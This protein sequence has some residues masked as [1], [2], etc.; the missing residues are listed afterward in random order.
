MTGFN[1]GHLTRYPGIHF[2]GPLELREWSG[3]IQ[4]LELQPVTNPSSKSVHA[5][6][7]L[8]TLLSPGNGERNASSSDHGPIATGPTL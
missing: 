1:L 2:T 5:E 7:I 6:N 4:P 8:R 3:S